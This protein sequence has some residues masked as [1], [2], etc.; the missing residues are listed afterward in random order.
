MRCGTKN[1]GFTL[2]EVLVALLIFST[3][4]LG[5][6]SAGTQNI[7]IM[8]KIEQKQIAGIIA[9]NQLILLQ[10]NGQNLR[11]G[12]QKGRSEMAGREWLWQIR[13]EETGQQGFYKLTANVELVNGGQAIVTRTAFARRKNGGAP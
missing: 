8:D 10:N 5:L 7:R 9:D 2:V 1:D 4:I 12:S 13:T 11:V 3:A 6:M